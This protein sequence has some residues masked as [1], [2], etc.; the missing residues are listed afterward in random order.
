MGI[1]LGLIVGKPVG[2]FLATFL[3]IKFKVSSL[4]VSILWKHLFGAG[5][6]AGIGFTMSIFITLLAFEDIHLINQAKI[7]IMLAS[8]TSGIL[9]FLWLK[10]TLRLPITGEVLIEE[11]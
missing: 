10:S 1:F 7:A 2:I 6:I 11:P 8:L 3:A 5:M 4:P 9:G